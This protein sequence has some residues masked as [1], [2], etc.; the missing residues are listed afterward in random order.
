[1][2]DQI[3]VDS[4]NLETG[5]YDLEGLFIRLGC[6]IDEVNAKRVVIDTID[7]LFGAFS[8]RGILRSELHRLFE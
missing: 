1:M 7:M 5:E 6:A 4:E 3:A 8:D 2:I